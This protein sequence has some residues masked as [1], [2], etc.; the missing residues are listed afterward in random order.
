M[1]FTWPILRIRPTYTAGGLGH[2]F[3]SVHLDASCEHPERRHFDWDAK[4][5]PKAQ[6]GRLVPSAL[7]ILRAWHAAG[8][9]IDRS[10]LGGF[11]EWSQHIRA[12]LLWLGCADPCD[13]TLKLKAQD[14]EVMQLAA[15]MA[16]W[17]ECIGL[18]APVNIQG[19]I[20]KAL[21]APDLQNALLAVAEARGRSVISSERLG[22]WLCK[23]NGRIVSGNALRKAGVVHGYPNWVLTR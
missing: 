21:V 5:V 3:A 19:I 14:A 13:T 8:T 2:D 6:R 20:N 22:M 15:V 10:P 11:E 16:C 12:A 23:V 17:K 7:T 18:N 9:Q 4:D 1:S